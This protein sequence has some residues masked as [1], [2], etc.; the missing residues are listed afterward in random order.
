MYIEEFSD[1]PIIFLTGACLTPC[2]A[3]CGQREGVCPL[4]GIPWYLPLLWEHLGQ[5]QTGQKLILLA[6][7]LSFFNSLPSFFYILLV[8][9][10]TCGSK[11]KHLYIFNPLHWRQWKLFP[12]IFLD[13]VKLQCKSSQVVTRSK[14]FS[15]KF[16][17]SINFTV[18]ELKVWHHSDNAHN[19][20]FSCWG[21]FYCRAHRGGGETKGSKLRPS[22]LCSAYRPS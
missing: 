10:F 2:A 22:V 19:N 17:C 14:L 15:W 11:A 7:F 4:T 5:A 13:Q 3:P 6:L 20:A 8:Y 12:N 1:H 18:A 21:L 9:L 16:K